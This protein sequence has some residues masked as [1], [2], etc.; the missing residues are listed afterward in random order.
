MLLPAYI[1]EDKNVKFDNFYKNYLRLLWQRV[2]RKKK[3]FKILEQSFVIFTIPKVFLMVCLW[4]SIVKHSSEG[5]SD[6]YR[7]CTCNL[8]KDEFPWWG[9]TVKK[10]EGTIFTCTCECVFMMRNC[11][12]VPD[13]IFR[14]SDVYRSYCYHTCMRYLA[15][16]HQRI[17]LMHLKLY[18]KRRIPI[19]HFHRGLYSSWVPHLQRTVKLQNLSYTITVNKRWTNKDRH[20][21]KPKTTAQVNCRKYFKEEWE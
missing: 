18:Q 5:H 8:F 6:E 3:A 10:H 9:F 17:Q 1:Y 21:N 7:S 11:S 16:S 12:A 20:A 2:K 15:C 14:A 19:S 13:L 4:R